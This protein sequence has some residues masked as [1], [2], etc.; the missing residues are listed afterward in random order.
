MMIHPQCWPW[1]HHQQNPAVPSAVKG[2]GMSSLARDL[3]VYAEIFFRV[4]W[5]S[6]AY[7]EGH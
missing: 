3:A 7:G 2:K 1:A 6:H 5:L 4:K